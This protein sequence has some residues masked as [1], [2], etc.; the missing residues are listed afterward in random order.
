MAGSGGTFSRESPQSLRDRVRRVEESTTG[1]ASEAEVSRTLGELL[2]DINGRDHALVRE[3]L[4]DLKET[5]EGTIEGTVDQIFGGSVAKHTHVDGLSDIDSLL[6]INET[7]LEDK[8]PQAVLEHMEECIR[9]GVEDGVEVERG[10][11]AVTVAYPDGMEIQLLPAI[12]GPK[13]VCACRHLAKM[14][15]QTSIQRHS[16]RH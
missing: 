4:T 12:G 2:G 16:Q 8:R 10:Q 14:A 7:D 9:D 5:L 1:A 3:R 6:L 11:M 15:G 13:G